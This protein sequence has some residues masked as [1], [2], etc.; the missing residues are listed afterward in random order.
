MAQ[1]DVVVIGASSGGV[2][3]LV[4]LVATLPEDFRSASGMQIYVHR[5]RIACAA[6]RPKTVSAPRSIGCFARPL[7]ITVRVSSA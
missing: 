6:V 7:I 1:R 2:E 4:K 3:V 5:G